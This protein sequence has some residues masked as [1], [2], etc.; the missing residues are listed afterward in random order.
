VNT[1]E[2]SPST[3]D[4]CRMRIPSRKTSTRKTSC[5][6][7][8]TPSST[9]MALATITVSL[10]NSSFTQSCL[11]LSQHVNTQ[12]PS[13]FTVKKRYFNP[14]NRHDPISSLNRTPSTRNNKTT[15]IQA[16]VHDRAI[17][18]INSQAL[19]LFVF[20]LSY[21]NDCFGRDGR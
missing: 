8:R 10:D 5:S 17:L 2:A 6:K 4:I 11:R 19:E 14:R 21:I 15:A 16:L 20:V 1:S 9:P 18:L 13:E 12:L 7:N 3:P